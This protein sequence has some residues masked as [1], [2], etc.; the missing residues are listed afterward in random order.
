MQLDVLLLLVFEAGDV[1]DYHFGFF[2]L[3]EIGDAGLLALTDF[4]VAEFDLLLDVCC[5]FCLDSLERATTIDE[6]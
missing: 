3:N 6:G 1:S 4:D 2:L 5:L